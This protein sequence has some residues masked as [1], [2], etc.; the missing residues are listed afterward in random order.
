[1][2]AQ[3]FAAQCGESS[4]HDAQNPAGDL[5]LVSPNLERRLVAVRA[6]QCTSRLRIDPDDPESSFLL[7]K[8]EDDAPECGDRM[9][10]LA[11]PLPRDVLA[12]VRAWVIEAAAG[13]RDGGGNP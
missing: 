11:E 12:C 3:V 1:V 6:T 9:P 5:D 4:C 10:V 13:T 2:P 7:E 8:L